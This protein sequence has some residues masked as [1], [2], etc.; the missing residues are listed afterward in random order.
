MELLKKIG[1]ISVSNYF[2]SQVLK[3]T[4]YEEKIKRDFP[5]DYVL[6]FW[7]PYFD[8]VNAKASLVFCK[9]VDWH[10]DSDSE[11]DLD[12]H[13]SITWVL[14]TKNSKLEVRNE[15]GK[16][17][18]IF[19]KKGDLIRFKNC[20][21]HRVLTNENNISLFLTV[22]FKNNILNSR[23]VKL[24][25]ENFKNYILSKNLELL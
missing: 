13:Y 3:Q 22:D 23:G 12:F 18:Y 6:D 10:T 16:L 8:S 2:L 21:E 1:E 14:K 5:R 4:Q 24:K 11:D 9:D 7:L 15:K 25:L 20:E 19:L 17:E